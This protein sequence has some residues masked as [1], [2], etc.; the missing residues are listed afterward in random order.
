MEHAYFEAL[1]REEWCDYCAGRRRTATLCSATSANL[2][3]ACF[4]DPRWQGT[5]LEV[6]HWRYLFIYGRGARF[7]EAMVV[8]F[9]PV[10]RL[11]LEWGRRRVERVVRRAATD[12]AA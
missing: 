2:P 5:F 7:A 12:A 11:T 3:P 8:L 9:S 6:G 4:D 1:A 10:H